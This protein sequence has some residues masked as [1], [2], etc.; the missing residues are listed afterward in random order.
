VL[1]PYLFF[2]GRRVLYIVSASL[3]IAV[4]VAG[5]YSYYRSPISKPER[6]LLQNSIS[7]DLRK[8]NPGQEPPAP[9][10]QRNKGPVSPGQPEPIPPYVNLL[11]LSVLLFG[12]DTGLKTTSKWVY[13]EQ[14][15]IILE[16]ENVE[17]Q[18]A[19]LKHQISPHFFMNTLN[20]IHALIDIDSAEAKKSVIRLS[21]LMRYLLHE[22]DNKLSPIEKE[23]EF[24]R[25]YVD[26]MK[27][28]YPGGV[29]ITLSIPDLIPDKSIPPLLFISLIENAFKHGISY[30]HESFIDIE[31][32]FASDSLNLTII[33]SKSD[34]NESLSESGIGM[35][36]TRKRLDL[37]YKERYAL[38][39]TDTGKLYVTSLTIPI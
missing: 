10:P 8:R 2:R 9:R 28:R 20:N 12:F 16:K 37:L 11:I 35:Q 7:G 34:R 31:L 27:L 18:L 6:N 32:R 15:R 25:S 19:F 29:R 3:L 33:N 4:S 1:L 24:I 21:N 22:S 5:M 26:L 39:V 17:T 13:S 14:Q 36:N 38:D 30:L 23:V